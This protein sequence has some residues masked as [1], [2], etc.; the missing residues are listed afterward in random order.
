MAPLNLQKSREAMHLRYPNSEPHSPGSYLRRRST[1]NQAT[2]AVAVPK[3]PPR[4]AMDGTTC[5]TRFQVSGTDS[6]ERSAEPCDAL[7]TALAAADAQE[8]FVT[9]G[10]RPLDRIS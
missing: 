6:P 8:G 4:S 3:Q 1:R 5:C 2:H 10:E 9:G 7:R